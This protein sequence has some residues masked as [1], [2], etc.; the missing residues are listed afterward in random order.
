MCATLILIFYSLNIFAIILYTYPQDS[1]PK[2][3][4][5]ANKVSGL[6][7]DIIEAL[8]A[9][10]KKSNIL[11]AYKSSQLMKLSEIFAA[12]QR[13]EIQIFVGAGYDKERENFVDYI[14]FPLY[15]IREV[16]VIRKG[17]KEFLFNSKNVRIGVVSGTLLG[18]KASKMFQNY[19]ILSFTNTGELFKALDE[20]KI[21]T[22][23][24]ST[25][26]GGYFLSLFPNKYELMYAP[27][28][29]YYHYV[30]VSKKLDDSIKKHIHDAV[31]SINEKGII[32]VIIKSRKLSEFVLPGNV[33]EIVFGDW[34]P[35]EWY[36]EKEKKAKGFDVETVDSVLRKLGFKARFL[37]F[38]WQ[39]CS[40]LM[41]QKVYDAVLTTAI[42]EERKE[43]IIFSDEPL[44]VGYD[45]LFKLKSNPI[46]V[47][48]LEKIPNSAICLYTDGY[49]YPEWFWKAPFRKEPIID[50]VDGFLMLKSKRADFFICN[51]TVG[52]F[53]A[54]ELKMESEIEYSKDFDSK[55]YY[56]VGFSNTY[57]GRF[58][59]NIF[60]PELKEFKLSKE[61]EKILNKYGLTYNE[62][63]K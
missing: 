62:L 29:K 26:V 42:T 27:T 21:H 17:T 30:V 22:A 24:T 40:E 31:K 45:V 43:F 19:E 60:S 16:L 12:I 3:Y 44:S 10:L 47:R 7:N 46:D 8:N 14:T 36:D 39:R 49:A 61:Y 48:S 5:N 1:L 52:K 37:T 13:N 15:G 34:K 50:D 6:C 63:W 53:L 51:I 59:S 54:K 9:E 28:E 38:P 18:N 33:V 32:D 23:Y 41:M 57:H 2:Y 55:M 4:S 56:Y 35:Y 25:L 58:L 11:I 20:G